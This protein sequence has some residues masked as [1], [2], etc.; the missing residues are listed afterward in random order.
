[1][2]QLADLAEFVQ[3]I[4]GNMTATEARAAHDTTP[5]RIVRADLV[6]PTRISV[7]FSES[8][9]PASAGNPANWRIVKQGGGRMPILAATYDPQNGDRVDL[10]T[11]LDRGC[12]PVT[13]TV[14]AAGAIFDLAD[15]AS[16]GARNALDLADPGNVFSVTLDSP[17]TV[18]IGSSGYDDI[19]VKVHDV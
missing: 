4:D 2:R 12:T 1:R 8:I 10:D 18:S 7:W 3:S 17:L 14:E 5:P 9:D 16:G 11:S 19:T 15:R 6:S 13:Y